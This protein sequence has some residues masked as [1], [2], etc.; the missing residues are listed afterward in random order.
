[1]ARAPASYL[2]V[3]ALRSL[4]ITA[5]ATTLLGCQT[6]IP[7]YEGPVRPE[8]EVALLA[9]PGHATIL[10]VDA[11]DVDRRESLFALEPGTHVVLFRVRRTYRDFG[12]DRATIEASSLTPQFTTYCFITLDMKAGHRY[13]IV[14]AIW[15]AEKVSDPSE[16]D[17]LHRSHVTT[18]LAGVRDETIGEIVPGS[19]CDYHKLPSD[20]IN[21]Y[22]PIPIQDIRRQGIDKPI[23]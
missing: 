7:L 13:A 8:N 9:A 4:L 10:Q 11:Q 18:V 12:R 21:P 3:M 5:V 6:P 1:M 22:G 15:D 20:G 23:L 19:H 2:P 14:S 17:P 16:I